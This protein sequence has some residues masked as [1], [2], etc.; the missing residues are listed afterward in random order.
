M[1]RLFL[2]AISILLISP[3]VLADGK[4]KKKAG[5]T[6]SSK[7]WNDSTVHWM[8]LDEVQV[9][10]QKSPKKVWIDVYTDWCGWCKVMDRKTF[11]NLYVAQ[12]MN[13][14]FYS[15][16]F[17]AEQKEPITFMGKKYEFDPAKG[18]HGFILGYLKE[19]KYPS[20][21]CFDKN[22]VFLQ[23][24]GGYQD[25]ANME[26]ILKYFAQALD[27]K[28]PW[29]SYQQSFKPSWSTLTTTD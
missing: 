8:T 5:S 24:V 9:A 22:F 18:T 14:H 20:A 28:I 21:L 25:V 29:D 27:R 23:S 6:A 16:K 12:Y 7:Q 26:M 11:S 17:N 10:M 3:A 1:K 19:L 2:L 15:V 13:E 4:D